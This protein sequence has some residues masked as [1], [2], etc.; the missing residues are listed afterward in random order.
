[1][2]GHGEN[3]NNTF[4]VGDVKQSIYK[5]RMARPDLFIGKYNT[6]QRLG[7]DDKAS[8]DMIGNCIILT[9]NFR[10]EINVL[11]TVNALFEQLMRK[12]IG[13]IEYDDAARLNSKYALEDP[14]GRMSEP[15]DV[16]QGPKSELIMIDGDTVSG[17]MDE[18]YSCAQIEAKYIANKIHE[19]V[20][21][22]DPMYIHDG[23]GTVRKVEYSDIVIL[24]RS[25]SGSATVFDQVFED[26]GIPIY[27]Q[28]ESG[29]FGAVVGHR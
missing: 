28:S 13:G 24:L 18:D 4:M 15:G 3:I 27:I 23:D 12:E 11:R 5:F 6:Y 22:D 29:Y 2:A 20:D 14:H 26:E 19:I 16:Y 9:R 17:D 8:A 21:G 7:D 1:M 10:S 25:V